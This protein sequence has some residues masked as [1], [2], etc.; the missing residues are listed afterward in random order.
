M[1][2]PEDAVRARCTRFAII[3]PGGTDKDELAKRLSDLFEVPIEDIQ[4]ILPPGDVDVV[5]QVGM[6]TS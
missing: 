4:G 1:C 6:T 2:C 3:I 5:E